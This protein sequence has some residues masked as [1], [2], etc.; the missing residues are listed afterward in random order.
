M[1]VEM[2]ATVANSHSAATKTTT[3]VTL[4][5][6]DAIVVV[7]VVGILTFQK[8]V[9]D[10]FRF[11]IA[12]NIALRVQH[13]QALQHA[14]A[15]YAAQLRLTQ[16]SL[17]LR[18]QVLEVIAHGTAIQMRHNQQRVALAIHKQFG[19]IAQQRFIVLHHA[20]I[21]QQLVLEL[22]AELVKHNLFQRKKLII[23]PAFE[24][25]NLTIGTSRHQTQFHI[26]RVK[27]LLR[28]Q[29]HHQLGYGH[30]HVLLLFF[31]FFASFF[32]FLFVC[33]SFDSL[34]VI[35]FFCLVDHTHSKPRFERHQRLIQIRDQRFGVGEIHACASLVQF[36]LR[37]KDLQVTKVSRKL[38]LRISAEH[39]HK[40]RHQFVS[41]RQMCVCTCSDL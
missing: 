34:F 33:F 35:R 1:A 6:V 16:A 14:I 39:S 8:L 22:D 9:H 38:Q 17:F 19:V 36:Q 20:P 32:F 21:A 3:M 40:F 26:F 27:L 28:L 4:L 11:D 31:F 18:V 15:Q 13:I 7:V 25:K 10:I 5:M 2:N 41:H 24:H 30:Q 37:M 23:L 29:T 12:M